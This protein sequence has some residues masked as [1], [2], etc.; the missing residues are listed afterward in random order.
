MN[1]FRTLLLREWM[2][3]RKGWFTLGGVPLAL[4]LIATIFGSV[5]TGIEVITPDKAGGLLLAVVFITAGVILALAYTFLSFQAG[6]LARRDQQD[7]SIEFWLSLPVPQSLFLAAMV[8]MHLFVMP[9]MVLAIGLAGGLALAPMFVVKGLGSQAL[10]IIDWGSVRSL[11]ALGTFRLAV[12]VVLA[13]VWALPFFL[14]MMA[15]SAWIKRWGG[16]AVLGGIIILGAV[17]EKF[18]DLPQ[19]AM[20]LRA[21][22]TRALAALIPLSGNGRHN[23]ESGQIT[24]ANAQTI[25]QWIWSDLHSIV[26]DLASPWLL[27]ALAVSLACA[28]AVV[29]RRNRGC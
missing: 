10:S 3:H 13:G 14:L 5:Q 29:V 8:L 11:L 22:S 6:S 25:A 28:A 20:A 1:E 21:L 19:L 2:Q 16:G 12:G 24:D 27:L 15:A 26:A 23:L 4:T 9:L 17:L 7:R 18:Y